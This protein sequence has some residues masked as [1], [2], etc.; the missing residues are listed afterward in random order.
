MTNDSPFARWDEAMRIVGAEPDR[1]TRRLLALVIAQMAQLQAESGLIPSPPLDMVYLMEIMRR[2]FA[3]RDTIQKII[4]G[5]P[6]GELWAVD[7][8]DQETT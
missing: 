2:T 3:M 1:V 6:A 8:D 5:D 4:Q 7:E